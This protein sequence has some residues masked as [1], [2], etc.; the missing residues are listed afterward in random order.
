V[1]QRRGPMLA[2]YTAND[3]GACGDAPTERRLAHALVARRGG[4]SHHAAGSCCTGAGTARGGL[5]SCEGARSR[6]RVRPRVHTDTR[7]DVSKQ[8]ILVWWT[9]G[10]SNVCGPDDCGRVGSRRVHGFSCDWLGRGGAWRRVPFSRSRCT[11]AFR[12]ALLNLSAVIY[13]GMAARAT[14][15]NQREHIL[16][17]CTTAPTCIC[18]KHTTS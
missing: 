13:G 9:R 15:P 16:K 11:L 4:G 1:N 12:P 2:A 3:Q 8:K 6:S 10:N 17:F 7:A 5:S 14:L 18:I